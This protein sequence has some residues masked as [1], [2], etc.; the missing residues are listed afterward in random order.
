MKLLPPPGPEPRRQL[1]QL[2]VVLLGLAVVAWYQWPQAAPIAPTSNL[3]PGQPQP[4]AQAFTLPEP[5][6]L[7]DLDQAPPATAVG[8][9]P[10]T[11]GMRPAPV[12]QAVRSMPATGQFGEVPALLQGPPPIGL[13]LAGMMV[14]PGTSRTM[15]TLKDPSTWALFHAFEGDVV[16]GRYKLVKVGDKSVVVS[17]VDG[18]GQ[19][20]LGLGN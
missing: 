14:A 18:S 6:R 3:P 13:R 20:T 9:N 1:G 15:A 19:R 7:G 5:V 11:F 10:F 16:D 8:R 4:S 12:Q 2:G 17:Y